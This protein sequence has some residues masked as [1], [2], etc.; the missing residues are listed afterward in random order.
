MRDG[1]RKRPTLKELQEKQ[2]LFPNSYLSGMLDDLL[3]NEIIELLAP[4]RPEEVG[5]TIDPK[6]CRYHQVI[7]HPLEKCITL[8]ERIMQLARDAKL[9][10]DLDDSVGTNH[11][12]VEVEYPHLSRQQ[13]SSKERVA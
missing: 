12:F 10:L 5:R 3:K 9:I 8:N 13:R 7:S 1:G 6:Y 11:V 4:K 2:Y